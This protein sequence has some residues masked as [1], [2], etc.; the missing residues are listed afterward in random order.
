MTTDQLLT[1]YRQ[2]KR[3]FQ[4]ANLIGANLIGA[5]LR[6]AVSDKYTFLA[7]YGIGS[8]RRQTLFIPEIDKI[9]CGCFCGT[10]AEFESQVAKT[11]PDADDHYRK[12]YEA[13]IVYLKSVA[14]LPT[15]QPTRS[16]KGQ[17]MLTI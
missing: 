3:D 16:D 15:L 1:D 5:D 6:G 2:G 4:N 9:W 8:A 14:A 13:A 10:M 12:Q 7:V 11:Y 17:E